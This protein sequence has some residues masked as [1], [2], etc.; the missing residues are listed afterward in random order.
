[1]CG[2]LEPVEPVSWQRRRIGHLA[3]RGNSRASQ[4]DRRVVVHC[5]KSIRWAEVATG[6]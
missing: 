4:L 5:C 1:M 3:V 6:C 2:Q